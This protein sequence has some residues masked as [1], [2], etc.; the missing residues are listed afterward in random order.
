VEDVRI[1]GLSNDYARPEWMILTVL[2]VPPLL[3][4]LNI[5]VRTDNFRELVSQIILTASA[6]CGSHHLLQ[7]HIATY[8]D[9]DIAGQPTAMQKGNRPV[10]ALRSR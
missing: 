9:N 10:K 4:A 5:L 8:M 2:P 3:T 7:Y 1:M 6:T